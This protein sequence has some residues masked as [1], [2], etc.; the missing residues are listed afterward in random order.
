MKPSRKA[1]GTR[2]N[3]TLATL[4]LVHKPEK[5]AKFITAKAIKI[6]Y[7]RH[8]S[9]TFSWSIDKNSVLLFLL[10]GWSGF[11]LCLLDNGHKVSR[12]WKSGKG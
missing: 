5:R 6:S 4:S 8:P 12:P 9:Y 3:E 7:K 1:G 10:C 2:S 11:P